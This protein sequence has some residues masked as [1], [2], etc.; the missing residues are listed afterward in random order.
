MGRMRETMAIIRQAFAG[1]RIS[2]TGQN[3]TLPRPCW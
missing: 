3:I 2:F 1:E